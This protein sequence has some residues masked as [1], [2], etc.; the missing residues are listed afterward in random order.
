MKLNK[1]NARFRHML[2]AANEAIGFVSGRVRQDLDRDRIL[3]L[4][5]VRLLEIV[6]EAANRVSIERRTQDPEI[7][8]PKVVGMRNRLIHGYDRVNFDVLWDTIRDVLTPRV[9]ALEPIVVNLP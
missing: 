2:D 4:A 6:G 9:A 5:L 8:W 3:N 7:P 1:K